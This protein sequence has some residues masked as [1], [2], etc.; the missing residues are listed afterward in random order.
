MLWSKTHCTRC[1]H[2]RSCP[3]K[4][5]LF[6][7]YCGSRKEHVAQDIDAARVDCRARRSFVVKYRRPGLL[8]RPQAVHS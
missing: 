3:L 4:T 2:Y 6:I 1:E 7:N 8:I 5:R